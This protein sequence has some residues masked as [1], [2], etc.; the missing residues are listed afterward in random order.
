MAATLAPIP[1][2]APVVE[3]K[4]WT[5]TQDW[6]IWLFSAIKRLETAAQRVKAVA[7]SALSATIATTTL[8]TTLEAGIYRVSYAF[9]V[10]TPATTSS[11]L[12]LTIGW[13]DGG[14]TLSQ[15]G[16]ALTGNLTTSQQNGTFLM[17]CDTASLIT[18]AMLY[19]SVGGT[20]MVYK[21]DLTVELVS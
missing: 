20:A 3:S 4:V 12:T 7:R 6:F 9:R 18:Y 8:Y 14:V 1:R 10:T 2:G 11:S 15:A 17:R 16:A 21:L 5:I 13:V 19:A